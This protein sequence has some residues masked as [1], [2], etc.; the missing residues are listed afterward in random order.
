MLHKITTLPELA[1]WDALAGLRFRLRILQEGQSP[2]TRPAVGVGRRKLATYALYGNYP[3]DK[4]C[5]VRTFSD[6]TCSVAK[7][8]EQP[9]DQLQLTV[10]L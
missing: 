10:Q 6:Y 4:G 3:Y 8:L 2:T 7:Q 5:A 1:G 9:T